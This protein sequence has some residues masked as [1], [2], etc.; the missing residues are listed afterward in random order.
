MVTELTQCSAANLTG[1]VG[2]ATAIAATPEGQAL[3]AELGNGNKT[4][5]AP[6]NEAFVSNSLARRG[7]NVAD[8]TFLD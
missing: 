2:V 3:L 4:V 8:H 5:F 1:L 7:G 6:N